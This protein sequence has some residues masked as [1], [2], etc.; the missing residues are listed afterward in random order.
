MD[1][2]VD[3]IEGTSKRKWASI[4]S[5]PLLNSVAESIVIRRPMSQV[6]WRSASSG[7]TSSSEAR[8]LPRN[9]PP[10]AVKINRATSSAL[11]PRQ[12]LTEGGVLAVDGDQLAI[13]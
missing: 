7:V 5:R 10:E 2:H 13:T 12:A 6:G 3:G 11:S 9:G 1:D 8:S 4:T